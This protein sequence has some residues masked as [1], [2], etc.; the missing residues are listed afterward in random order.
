MQVLV[1]LVHSCHRFYYVLTDIECKRYNTA[2]FR[3][4]RL[5]QRKQMYNVLYA[6]SY[7]NINHSTRIFLKS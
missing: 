4:F 2:F 1:N 6:E 3:S 5:G 7:I